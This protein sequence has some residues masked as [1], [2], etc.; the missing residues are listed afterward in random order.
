MR[1]VSAK[2]PVKSPKII[3]EH[4][5]LIGHGRSVA[6]RHGTASSQVTGHAR[7]SSGL[8]LQVTQGARDRPSTGSIPV[9]LRS[10]C[11]QRACRPESAAAAPAVKCVPTASRVVV[12]RGA[13]G[14]RSPVRTVRGA[15]PRAREAS[16]RTSDRTG[17]PGRRQG[18]TPRSGRVRDRRDGLD[19]T[20]RPTTRWTDGAA[21]ARW[22]STGRAEGTSRGRC[23]G[24]RLTTRRGR[25]AVGPP[26]RSRGGRAP[27]R[28][29]R[30]AARDVPVEGGRPRRRRA[31]RAGRHLG[32]DP[33]WLAAAPGSR[34]GAVQH[35]APGRQ[36]PARTVGRLDVGL[37]GRL[38]RHVRRR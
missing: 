18:A 27:A 24:C 22:R 12:G 11:R 14:G 19:G 31:G 30:P 13:A 3:R 21:G 7:R 17:H 4:T 1:H 2:K 38:G 33:G 9:R 15:R 16:V 20:H 5:V 10:A 34:R 32:D 26:A 37:P 6:G 36:C 25:A 35:L 8:D 29:A 28:R 23:R